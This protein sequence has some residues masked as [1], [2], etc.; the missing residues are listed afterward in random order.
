MASAVILAVSFATTV[1]FLLPSE[2]L[3]ASVPP[4]TP[5]VPNAAALVLAAWASAPS[6]PPGCCHTGWCAG[7]PWR[8]QWSGWRWPH[9]ELLGAK[10]AVEQLGTVEFGG[11][12]DAVELGDELGDFLLQRLA[13]ARAVGGIGRLHCQFTHPLQDVACC[14]HCPSATWA[15]GCRHWHCGLPGSTT[16]LAGETLGDGQARGIV[17][18]LLM[19]SPEDRRWIEVLSEAW[20]MPRLRCAVSELT[21]VLIVAAMEGLLEAVNEHLRRLKPPSGRQDGNDGV[22]VG[23]ALHLQ[24]VDKPGKPDYLQVH[25]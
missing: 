15:S 1:M 21:L 8:P 16:D 24:W 3:M 18:A 6:P 17:L 9:L 20:L 13:V 14:F 25:G 2:P 19:R 23:K 4:T 10:G 12:R 5:L 22:I 11:L 7:W